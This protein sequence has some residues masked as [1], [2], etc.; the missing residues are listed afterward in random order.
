MCRNIF[1]RVGLTALQRHY[2]SLKVYRKF[3][4]E[5][6][7]LNTFRSISLTLGGFSRRGGDPTEENFLMWWKLPAANLKHMAAV[8]MRDFYLR[9]L[10]LIDF[11]SE[12]YLYYGLLLLWIFLQFW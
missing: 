11:W 4:S 7:E 2:D 5:K 3:E 9:L 10:V 1:D 6:I 12:T 8:D